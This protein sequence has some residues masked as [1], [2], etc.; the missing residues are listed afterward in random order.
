MFVIAQEPQEQHLRREAPDWPKVRGPDGPSR[1]EALALRRGQQSRETNDPSR[2]HGRDQTVCSRGN[3]LH[4][5]G[6]DEGGC[7]GIPGPED[8]RRRGDR[9]GLLQ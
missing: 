9:A 5:P 8:Q 2:V 6:Q 1:Y 3:Q 4:G 7:R